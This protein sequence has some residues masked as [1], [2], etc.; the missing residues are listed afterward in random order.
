M[1]VNE[2]LRRDTVRKAKERK[3]RVKQKGSKT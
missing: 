3:E 2:K 1:N